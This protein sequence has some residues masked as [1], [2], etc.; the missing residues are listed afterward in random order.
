[1]NHSRTF[2][3]ALALVAAALIL[4]PVW[5]TAQTASRAPSGSTSTSSDPMGNMAGVGKG[6]E[7]ITAEEFREQ[8]AWWAHDDRGGREPGTPGNI[9]AGNVAAAEFERLGLE[10]CGDTGKDG[11]RSFF[12]N[13]QKGGKYGYDAREVLL[14]IGDRKWGLGKDY[15]LAGWAPEAD[16]KNLALVFAGYGVVSRKLEYDDYQGVDVKDKAVLL[17]T[18]EPQEKDPGS[19][20]NGTKKIAAASTYRKV[21][22]AQR[23]G[24]RLVILVDGPLH[25]D[26]ARDPLTP[27][28]S[29][30]SSRCPVLHVRRA[31]A[32]ALLEGSGRTLESL[33]QAI[34][35]GTPP[36]P[37]PLALRSRVSFKAVRK[38]LHPARNVLALFRGSHPRL[39][40]EVLI[41]GAHYDH[42][43]VGKYGSRA[44]SRIGEIHNGADD[45]ATGSVGVLE[46]AEAIAESGVK[47]KRSVLFMLFDAEEKGLYGSRYYVDHPAVPLDKTA[48][49][50]N[51]DMIGYVKNNRMSVGGVGSCAAWE[52]ILKKAEHGSPLTWR[53]RSSTGGGSDHLSFV[54]RKIPV[55]MFN[56]GL[57]PYYHTPDDDARRCNPE[58]AR[59]VLRT[60]FRIACLAANLDRKPVWTTGRLSTRLDL[61]VRISTS[62]KGARV[63]SV[64]GESPAHRAGLKTGDILVRVHKSLV[65]GRLSVSRALRKVR[66]GQSVV[67][68]FLR[69]GKTLKARVEFPKPRKAAVMKPAQK[70]KKRKVF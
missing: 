49:M 31:V 59:E 5:S 25:R 52:G 69:G 41:I 10:R 57:H 42:I 43:G 1:M 3:S 40:D 50:I 7:S 67:V 55:L 17:F 45:N 9:E 37:A 19:L 29:F 47:T 54:A 65:K 2:T 4:L 23:K 36:A 28:E 16:L 13:F 34:D 6:V 14:H 15:T 39:R 22:N 35:S 51:M 12:Q 27:N 62:S 70:P 63:L 21:R 58:G 48:A 56:S 38:L 11:K 33:Q 30:R 44:R 8:L 18:Y 46:L 68:E 20:W 32:E 64:K 26:P 53:H 66:P 60:M 61:G 24:A